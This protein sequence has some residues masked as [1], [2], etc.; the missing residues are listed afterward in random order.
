MKSIPMT[1]EQVLAL[2]KQALYGRAPGSFRR[3][4]GPTCADLV[5]WLATEH[6]IRM[7]TTTI[8]RTLK[9]SGLQRIGGRWRLLPDQGAKYG[10]PSPSRRRAG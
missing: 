8:S 3:G 9:A 2:C 5:G 10:K 4:T 6:R 1:D 7:S